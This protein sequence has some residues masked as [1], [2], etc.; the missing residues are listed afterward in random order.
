MQRD[1]IPV[2]LANLD[3]S[4]LNFNLYSLLNI[5]D[6]GWY[7]DNILIVVPLCSNFNFTLFWYICKLIPKYW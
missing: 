6:A 4:S 1:Q 2:I 3:I 7:V 5:V